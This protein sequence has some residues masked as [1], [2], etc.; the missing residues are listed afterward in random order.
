MMRLITDIVW[1]F[2]EQSPPTDLPTEVEVPFE[3]T[4]YEVADYL[5]DKYGVL[6]ETFDNNLVCELCGGCDNIKYYEKSDYVWCENCAD[7]IPCPECGGWYFE[8][9]GPVCSGCDKFIQ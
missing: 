6:V 4:E 7:Q 5:T 3:L 1:S 2:E 8:E 9:D